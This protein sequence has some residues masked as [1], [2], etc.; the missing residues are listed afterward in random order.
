[1]AQ[2]IISDVG[3]QSQDRWKDRRRRQLHSEHRRWLRLGEDEEGGAQQLQV[4]GAD[5]ER[6]H[7]VMVMWL[8][9]MVS[10]TIK[11]SKSK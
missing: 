2:D 6:Q 11:L 10:V 7:G 5:A 4:D 3:Q 8:F 1:M 9:N